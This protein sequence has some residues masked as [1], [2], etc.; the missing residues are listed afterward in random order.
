MIISQ[1]IINVKNL[2]R[3]RQKSRISVS[4]K[5]EIY[6]LFKL[7]IIIKRRKLKLRRTLFFFF[8]L[9]CTIRVVGVQTKKSRTDLL[10]KLQK[11]HTTLKY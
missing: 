5:V 10:F 1:I 4:K 11:L 2:K 3:R 8:T 6:K 7:I 9:L